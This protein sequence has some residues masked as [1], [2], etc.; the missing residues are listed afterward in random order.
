MAAELSKRG[1]IAANTLRNTKGVDIVCSNEDAS[2]SVAIQV[3][4]NRRSNRDWMLNQKCED[5]FAD[6]LFYV[7]V[8]LN[9]NLRPPDFFIVP[10]KAV[11]EYTR[12]NHAEWLNTPGRKG[13]AR[14]DST[15]RKFSDPEERYRNRWELLGL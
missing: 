5:Y 3:K 14:N 8:T 15:V 1:Y 11:A 6:N 12:D 7:F 13:Q 4:T 2:R 10:S 9:N